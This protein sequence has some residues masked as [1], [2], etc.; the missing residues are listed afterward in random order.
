M[1]STAGHGAFSP[2]A[3]GAG[4]LVAE[5]AGAVLFGDPE[6]VFTAIA[7]PAKGSGAGFARRDRRQR[8]LPQLPGQ[9][10]LRT[11]STIRHAA[12]TRVLHTG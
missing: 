3:Q 9:E 1:P 6:R 7:V 5:P 4:S 11:D 12:S 2:L 8:T 10:R